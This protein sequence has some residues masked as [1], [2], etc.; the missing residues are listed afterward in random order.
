[1]A[2]ITVSRQAGSLGNEIAMLTAEKL[3]YEYIE[4][5]QISEILSKF[6]FTISEIDQ[7]DEKKPSIWQTLSVQKELFA[8]FIRAAICELA[9]RNNVVIVGR[10][11]Q[12]ILRDI[13]GTL[14]VRI[15]APY[16]T[17]VRRL[18]EQREYDEDEVQRII[19]QSDSDSSGY[20]STYFGEQWNDSDL[21]DLVINTRTISP[22]KSVETIVHALDTEEIKN[23]PRMSEAL[24]DFALRH[25]ANAAVLEIVG[26]GEWVTLD[27]KKGVATLSGLVRTPALKDDCENVIATIHGIKSVQNELSIRNQN[28][29]I[30]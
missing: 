6:G 13:P 8:H 29:T 21:Y 17:R 27:V 14:H 12:V 19:R 4:K 11:G 23:S 18:M 2:I 30:Y 26:G 25:K 22:E 3:G 9:S 24:F 28:T 10:G 7:F 15:I 16:E 20:L 1:M 5:V